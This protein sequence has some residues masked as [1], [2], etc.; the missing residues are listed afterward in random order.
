MQHDTQILAL[1]D[2]LADWTA[3]TWHDLHRIPER[4]FEEVK[5]AAY[6]RARL[7]EI[8]IPYTAE[9]T[10]T[11]GTIEGGLPGKT[12]ALRADIDALPIQENTGLPFAS[13]HPGMMHACGHDSHTAMLLGAARLL[14]EMRA[15]LPGT[16]RLLF[17]PAEETSGGAK[18]MIDAGAMKGVDAVYGLHVAAQAPVGRIATRP[19][20]MYAATDEFFIDVLGKSGHGAHPVSGVDAI[21]IAAQII[22]ALQTVITRETEATESAVFTVGSIHGGTACNIIADKVSLD[23]TLRTLTPEMRE[24]M[25]Q[26]IPALCEGIA[27][28]MGGD[29]SIRIWKGYCAAVNNA[30]EAGR[31]LS[32]AERLFGAE[33]TKVLAASSMGAEDFAYY[34]LEAPGAIYHLGCGG[35]VSVH[36]DGFTVDEGCLRVGVAMHAAMAFEY[37]TEH[38]LQ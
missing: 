9:R 12:V 23:C 21:V 28:A 32:V 18:P 4:G 16:V 20:P 19:G 15:S 2:S 8:G 27:Q 6:I 33:N 7:D 38:A 14:W 13:E 3:N 30:E 11:I 25:H 36:N 17:Q 5:T 35:S 22:T 34:L 10:W 24:W 1:A 31:V 37:L 26:R 29:V